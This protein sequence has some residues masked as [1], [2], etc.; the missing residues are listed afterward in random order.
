MEMYWWMR[1]N[2]SG[3]TSEVVPRGL[4]SA[5]TVALAGVEGHERTLGAVRR[6]R[7]TRHRNAPADDLNDRPLANAVITHLLV[8]GELDQNG[9]CL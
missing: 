7:A 8:R 6:S 2:V 3:W 1:A 5:N 4:E 9:A